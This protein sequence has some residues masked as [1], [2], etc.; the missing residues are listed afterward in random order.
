MRSRLFVISLATAAARRAAFTRRAD[1][2]LAWQFF[3]A[4]TGLDESLDYSLERAMRKG[5]RPLTLTELACY[6]SHYRLWRQLLAD[7]DADRYII[8]EDDALVDWR[9]FEQLVTLDSALVPWPLLHFHYSITTP[10]RRI[11]PL[12]GMGF[13]IVELLGYGFGAVAYQ[14]SKAGAGLLVPALKEVNIGI[15][16]A[17]ERGWHHG[18]RNLSVFPFPVCHPVGPTQMD[19][20]RWDEA[21]KPLL[22]KVERAIRRL[23]EIGRRALWNFPRG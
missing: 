10:T 14:I 3:D 18:V 1:T 15:D 2:D 23:I 17:M 9:F 7:P 16:M 20:E 4:S 5:G 11:E 21:P 6:S 8:F 19:G 22:L 13:D 12:I